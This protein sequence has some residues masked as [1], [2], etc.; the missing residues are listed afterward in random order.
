MKHLV[1]NALVILALSAVGSVAIAQSDLEKAKKQKA[2]LA[3]RSKTENAQSEDRKAKAEKDESKYLDELEQ[4]RTEIAK[5]E[6]DIKV[7]EDDADHAEK[8]SNEAK[9]EVIRMKTQRS[10]LFKKKE[11]TIDDK[12]KF[13]REIL[14]LRAEKTKLISDLKEAEKKLKESEAGADQRRADAE[15]AEDKF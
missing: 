5:I 13:D 12:A 7:R 10:E 6:A 14:D 11:A 2:E 8:Q 3:K 1:R 15:K 9:R 4:V